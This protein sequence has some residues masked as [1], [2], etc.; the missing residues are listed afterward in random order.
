MRSADPRPERLNIGLVLGLF[1][2]HGELKIRIETDI[3]QRFATLKRVYLDRVEPM[4]CAWDRKP[5]LI[6]Q[7]T[8]WMPAP[9]S[10]AI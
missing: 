1:G 7:S 6:W 4:T 9:R 3:P 2:V 5:V 8:W 10:S